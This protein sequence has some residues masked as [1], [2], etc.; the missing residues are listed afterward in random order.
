M[1]TWKGHDKGL[2]LSLGDRVGD[3]VQS[4]RIVGGTPPRDKTLPPRDAGGTRGTPE[5]QDGDG[6]DGGD[7]GGHPEGQPDLP[8]DTG[9]DK[10]GTGG[11]PP[12]TRPRPSAWACIF[13]WP[14]L[15]FS[16]ISNGALGL[17]K[18]CEGLCVVSL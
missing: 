7:P 13:A 11:T 8:G 2:T 14:C 9:R 18:P 12:G 16:K 6:R 1:Q 4:R 10:R 5:G 15:R 3:T 17:E